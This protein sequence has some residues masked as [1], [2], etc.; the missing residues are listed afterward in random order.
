MTP[1]CAG[2]MPASAS[3]L[4]AA[5]AAA[6]AKLTSAAT[7]DARPLPPASP[8]CRAAFPHAGRSRQPFVEGGRGHHNGAS[9]AHTESTVVLTGRKL[10]LPLISCP[11]PGTP[12]LPPLKLV[13]ALWCHRHQ[14]PPSMARRITMLS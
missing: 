8:A 4:A 1:T 6:S 5:T 13:S 11:Y 12:I 14:E 10:A 7:S 2:V 9:T 3:A